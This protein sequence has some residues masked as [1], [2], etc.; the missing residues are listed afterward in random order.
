MICYT[1]KATLEFCRQHE[2]QYCNDFCDVVDPVFS[3]DSTSKRSLFVNFLL[4]YC[5]GRTRV[6][7]LFSFW[8]R[9]RFRKAQCKGFVR[10]VWKLIFHC[11]GYV[12]SG[13][14]PLGFVRLI[15]SCTW[16]RMASWPDPSCTS[17]NMFSKQTPQLS[18][19]TY[20]MFFSEQI[21]SVPG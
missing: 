1:K 4:Q 2:G 19:I 9:L 5:S 15:S 18:F 16:T 21:P 13:G 10:A 6:K 14:P 20:H 12:V 7:L 3:V 8:S 11:S 17:Y